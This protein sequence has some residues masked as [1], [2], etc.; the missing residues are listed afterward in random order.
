MQ[1]VAEQDWLVAVSQHL[2]SIGRLTHSQRLYGEMGARAGLT[3]RP[4]LYGILV[5]IRERQPVRI[6]DVAGDMDYDRSTISRHVAEL[7]SLGCVARESDPADGRVVMLRLTDEGTRII[8][9]VCDAWTSTLDE[10]TADWHPADRETLLTLLARLD[11]A[12]TSNFTGP[13]RP[14]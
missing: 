11:A 8:E 5:R 3:L 2:A 13:P 4:Y 14:G 7:A 12:L 1:A 6:T 9:R 10:L